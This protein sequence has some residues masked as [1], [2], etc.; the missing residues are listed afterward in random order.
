[1]DYTT[2]ITEGSVDPTTTVEVSTS[3][4][5]GEG[6][7]MREEL[8][9]NILKIFGE[10]L[11]HERIVAIVDNVTLQTPDLGEANKEIVRQITEILSSRNRSRSLSP[12]IEVQPKK[13][14]HCDSMLVHEEGKLC[15]L[16]K[17]NRCGLR[18][19]IVDGCTW[20]EREGEIMKR[21]IDQAD[22]KLILARAQK[23]VRDAAANGLTL[24]QMLATSK[25]P[26]QKKE[27]SATIT[28]VQSY[29]NQRLQEAGQMLAM[30]QPVQQPQYMPVQYFQK[31]R[32]QGRGRQKQFRMNENQ[33]YLQQR[34]PANQQ[35]QF[36]PQ[37]QFQQQQ[38][39]QNGSYQPP[40]QA[41]YG[42]AASLTGGQQ[43][44]F[45]IS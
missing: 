40:Q 12:A 26:K 22:E 33:S 13:C 31:P 7:A 16:I 32:Q 42:G 6:D 5:W 36:N 24:E 9:M 10:S 20:N 1:M 41:R 2:K 25:A 4:K 30:Q 45:S 39:Q 43:G 19:H 15:P 11:S 27:V 44:R 35:Q 23:L 34:M 28:P 29:G 18:G 3:A 14:L 8:K 38:F 21:V 37:Q 17:C